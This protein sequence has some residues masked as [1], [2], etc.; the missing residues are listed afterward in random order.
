MLID[1]I[2]FILILVLI[3]FILFLIYLSYKYRIEK[4]TLPP[5]TLS[6]N[7]DQNKITNIQTSLLN[8]YSQ[9]YNDNYNQEINKQ[10]NKNLDIYNKTLLNIKNSKN[11]AN[12][13]L[14]LTSDSSIFPSDKSIKTIKSKFNSQYL[15][16][17]ENDSNKYGI[18]ANDK[19]VTVNGLC[20][21]EF[22]LLDC[23][24][25]LYSSNSQKFTTNRV[26]SATDAATIMNV[27]FTKINT[28]NE[29]PFNIFRPAANPTK[30]LK[31]SNDG[32]TIDKCNLNDKKQQWEIS[33]DENICYLS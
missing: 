3:C 5:V 33:P 14:G 31:I 24:N 2:Y 32:I 16:T 11:L 25:K 8:N 27:D 20:K 9:Y 28:V 19:C 7:N 17:F 23:Q 1:H 13:Q 26:N 22:C 10:N 4:F 15:S 29:Y 12:R 30:C 6:Y 21:G 18:L